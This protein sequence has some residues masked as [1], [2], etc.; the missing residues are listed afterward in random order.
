MF[1]HKYPYTDFHELNL[2]WFLLKF[3]TLVEDW[4]NFHRTISAEWDATKNDWLDLY[5]FVHDYFDNL[6]V[7]AEVDEVFRKLIESGEINELLLHALNSDIVV[8]SFYTPYGQVLP[9]EERIFNSGHWAQGF[10]IGEENHRPICCNCF[11]DGTAEGTDNIIVFT[12]MDTGLAKARHTIRSGHCNSAC[13]NGENFVIACGGGNSTLK[14]LVEIDLEGNI[15][16]RM[17][18][19]TIPWAITYNQGK[20]YVLDSDNHLVVL[21]EDYEM[22]EEHP[23]TLNHDYTYQG[24][25]SDDLY[26]YVPCGNTRVLT[27]TNNRNIMQVFYHD[28]TLYRNIEMYFPLEIE[29]CDI[30]KNVCYLASAT[31][32][33]CMIVLTDL[34]KNNLV[35]SM[36]GWEESHGNYITH[37][38][39]VD[40]T[41]TGFL[42]D[43]TRNHPFTSLQWFLILVPSNITTLTLNLLSDCPTHPITTT[44][45]LSYT[46]RVNGN[47][48]KVLRVNYNS[49]NT[50]IINNLIVI[51]ESGKSSVFVDSGRFVTT[52]LTIGEEESDL[53]VERALD[54]RCPYEMNGTVINS[55]TNGN[56]PLIYILGN[57]YMI[58]NTINSEVVG[59]LNICG[60]IRVDYT[61]PLY[62]FFRS[63]TYHVTDKIN[64]VATFDIDIS[65]L[66]YPCSLS[67]TPNSIHISNAPEGFTD[68]NI[69][70][71]ICEFIDTN[72]SLV[73]II[74]LDGTVAQ[75]YNHYVPT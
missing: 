42:M 43:G 41:Y 8:D 21:N 15:I 46:L 47:N 16:K 52:N 1:G 17:T 60:N 10:A 35:G 56:T 29:E 4:E 71:I 50:L 25:F 27:A 72:K 38:M 36:G 51:G 12:Y 24:I 49:P 65:E 28:G 6:D 69:N 48:H 9:T 26:L 61:F 64:M 59:K 68:A 30:Y 75:V 62:K 3:K 44:S 14:Q 39:Y 74:R 66:Y 54:L 22:I 55:N 45:P 70:A 11:T 57:G 20:Y 63:N 2:D 5:N 40:E 73:T 53:V 23:I 18:W 33:C 32:D 19:E 31:Q 7:Q 37:T 34:Y 67:I 13:F 58:N